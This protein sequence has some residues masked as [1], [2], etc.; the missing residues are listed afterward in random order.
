MT[1]VN[2]YEMN[3]GSSDFISK[4]YWAKGD[5]EIKELHVSF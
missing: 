2:I 3:A 4:C 5:R 1:I